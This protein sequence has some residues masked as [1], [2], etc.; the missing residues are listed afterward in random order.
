MMAE[1]A[2][3]NVAINF[4]GESAASCYKAAEKYDLRDQMLIYGVD[5][6]PEVMEMIRQ[7]NVD[8]SIVASFY[9]YGYRS[10][11]MLYAYITEGKKPEERIQDVIMIM[12]TKDN[13]DT[14]QE[15]LSA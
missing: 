9:E 11:E 15:E 5:E 4:A 12:V 14:Y 3:I 2:D 13:I 1:H 7:G 6:V 8:G 10:V